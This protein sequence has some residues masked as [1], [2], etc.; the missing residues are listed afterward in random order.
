MTKMKGAI[1]GAAL[2]G[3]AV[4]VSARAG[5]PATGAKIADI[6]WD[7]SN[8]GRL[9]SFDNH[10][11][12][13]FL[14][15]TKD[16][17]NDEAI[18]LY[19]GDDPRC[20]EGFTWTDLAGD[21]RYNLVV[22]FEPQGTSLT[23]TSAIYRRS[24]SGKIGVET[25]GGDGIALDGNESLGAPKLIQDLNGDGKYEFVVPEEWGSTMA[26]AAVISIKVYRLSDGRYVEASHD[27]PKFYEE[28]VLPK[29][30]SEISNIKRNPSSAEGLDPP[31]QDKPE[32]VD[33]WHGEPE[34]KLA[35]FEMDRDKILRAIGRDPKAGE[36]EAR[37]WVKSGD[38]VLIGDA[39]SVF[40]D[41][42]GHESDLRAAKLASKRLAGKEFKREPAH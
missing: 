37:A 5:S 9:R 29:L 28:Q 31:A 38:Y 25:I 30:E 12:Y 32:Q 19:V 33:E 36:E 16:A 13:N 24:S 21:H 23:N 34:R 2:L 20:I 41:M 10:E 40:E 3:F 35:L 8:I 18:R 42:G 27:F 7:E 39:I 1:A 4:I 17:V 22:V 26:S 11:V 14:V 6:A 15:Q